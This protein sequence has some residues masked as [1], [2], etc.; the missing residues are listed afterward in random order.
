MKMSTLEKEV[1]KTLNLKKADYRDVL[2]DL[3]IIE[4]ALKTS[5]T[6][7]PD[8]FKVQ[9]YNHLIALIRRIQNNE[10]VDI[11]ADAL[12][13]EISSRLPQAKEILD[14][15]L[16][17]YNVINSESEIKLMAIYL[18]LTAQ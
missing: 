8:A 3:Y 2:S 13:S 18:S 1:R 14:P 7:I 6:V 5:E 11:G 17:K 15:L 12:D 4:D 10:C 9:F 16:A